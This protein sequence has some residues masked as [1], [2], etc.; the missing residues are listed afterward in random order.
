[1]I[2][3]GQRGNLLLASVSAVEDIAFTMGTCL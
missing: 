1:M 3:C 2:I